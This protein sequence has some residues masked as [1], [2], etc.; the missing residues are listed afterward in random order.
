[1]EHDR[2][3]EHEHGEGEPHSCGDVTKQ[4]YIAEADMSFVDKAINAR[5]ASAAFFKKRL[6]TILE[7]ANSA[8]KSIMTKA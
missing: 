5:V 7:R 1:M 8:C 4:Y 3:H 6:K 2:K